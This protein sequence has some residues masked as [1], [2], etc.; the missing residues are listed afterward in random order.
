MA[1]M[2][3]R[4]EARWADTPGRQ[5]PTKLVATETDTLQDSK[6]VSSSIPWEP[7]GAL[8][9]SDPTGLAQLWQ[10]AMAREDSS[11]PCPG[12]WKE[13]CLS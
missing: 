13:P 9:W 1:I 5:K 10:R 12:F 2:C 8:R 3:L 4:R 7:K 6:Q 11:D